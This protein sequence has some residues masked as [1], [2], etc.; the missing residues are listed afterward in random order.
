[1][2]DHFCRDTPPRYYILSDVSNKLEAY[3]HHFYIMS[4]LDRLET[5]FIF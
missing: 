4:P 1:M 5:F 2:E 3:S